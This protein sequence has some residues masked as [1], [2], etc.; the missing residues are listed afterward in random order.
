MD[1][2][3]ATLVML[4]RGIPGVV[5][6]GI[7]LILMLL[8]LI[9]KESGLMVAAAILAIPATYVFGAW[10]GFLLVVRLLPLFLLA[11]AF[12]I[13]RDEMI[14]GWIFPL[15]VLGFQIYFLVNMV[16]SNFSGV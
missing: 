16:A 1:V 8:A 7:S 15:P 13:S 11:S 5:V 12:F 14:F 3:I 6:A 9:R 2:V 4:S 10:A